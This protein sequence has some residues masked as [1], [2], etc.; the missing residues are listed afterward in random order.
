MVGI[1]PQEIVRYVDKINPF[2][3]M[4]SEYFRAPF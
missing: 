1:Y 2:Q 3:T 4:R